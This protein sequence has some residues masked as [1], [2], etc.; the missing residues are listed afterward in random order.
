MI[1][2]LRNVHGGMTMKALRFKKIS[3]IGS[4]IKTSL[5]MVI[6]ILFIGSITVL[7]NG[8]PIQAYQDFLDSFWGG[9]L[10]KL[11]QIIQSSTVGNLAI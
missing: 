11:I 6:P 7:L 1:Y 2:N 9:A 3:V 8:F 4:I 10:R 5:A